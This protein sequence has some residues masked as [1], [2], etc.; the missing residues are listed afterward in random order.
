MEPLAGAYMDNG[1]DLLLHFSQFHLV[2]DRWRLLQLRRVAKAKGTDVDPT[3]N[4]TLA[5]LRELAV[6][7]HLYDTKLEAKKTA[8]SKEKKKTNPVVSDQALKQAGITAGADWQ[9]NIVNLSTLITRGFLGTALI[10]DTPWGRCH[11]SQNYAAISFLRQPGDEPKIPKQSNVPGTQRL[12]IGS[13]GTYVD[14]SGKV[15]RNHHS[16]LRFRI[17]I[18]NDNWAV[19]HTK[20]ATYTGTNAQSIAAYR[21]PL[22]LNTAQGDNKSSNDKHKDDYP[23]MYSLASWRWM[24]LGK[25]QVAT[26]MLASASA[27]A[28]ASSSSQAGTAM[29]ADQE[30]DVDAHPFPDADNTSIVATITVPYGKLYYT[31]TVPNIVLDATNTR[32]ASIYIYHANAPPNFTEGRIGVME[33]VGEPPYTGIMVFEDGVTKAYRREDGSIVSTENTQIRIRLTSTGIG[34]FEKD[35]TLSEYSLGNDFDN[36]ATNALVPLV[37]FTI[38]TILDNSDRFAGKPFYQSIFTGYDDSKPLEQ[39]RIELHQ[40]A[41]CIFAMLRRGL[42]AE[43]IGVED[44]EWSNT[45]E[46]VDEDGNVFSMRIPDSRVALTAGALKSLMQKVVRVGACSW[47]FWGDNFVPFQYESE[48]T[49]DISEHRDSLENVDARV[50]AMVVFGLLCSSF[51][52]MHL[53]EQQMQFVPGESAAFKRLAVIMV[54]DSWPV[55]LPPDWFAKGYDTSYWLS[56]FTSY[57][58]ALKNPADGYHVKESIISHAMLVI[59]SAVASP[60]HVA[61]EMAG[62]DERRIHSTKDHD[63]HFTGDA[64]CIALQQQFNFDE[65]L[66]KF[67]HGENAAPTDGDGTVG[68]TNASLVR[69]SHETAYDP[70]NSVDATGKDLPNTFDFM[71]DVSIGHMH[72][73]AAMMRV[74]RAFKGDMDMMDR[75]ASFVGT[76]VGKV[77][78]HGG[79]LTA[80]HD[81]P[82]GYA[83]LASEMFKLTNSNPVWR[84]P[85][86]ERACLRCSFVPLQDLLVYPNVPRVNTPELARTGHFDIEYQRLLRAGLNPLQTDHLGNV[87][88][89]ILASVDWSNPHKTL[90]KNVPILHMIDQHVYRGIGHVW[91]G[92]PSNLKGFRPKE[93]GFEQRFDYIFNYVTGFNPR[94]SWDTLK[95]AGKGVAFVRSAQTTILATLRYAPKLKTIIGAQDFEEVQAADTLDRGVLAGGVG[96]IGQA[97]TGFFR[98]IVYTED[99]PIGTKPRANKHSVEL[100]EFQKLGLASEKTSYEYHLSVCIGIETPD[101]IVCTIHLSR[102]GQGWGWFC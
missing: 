23:G 102:A 26:A 80:K 58:L 7:S 79:L 63:D 49:A 81:E 59:A 40:D 22:I 51:G 9:K 16:E 66:T 17:S 96:C 29:D 64:V 32:V 44:D 21:L 73:A 46:T 18:P 82:V 34:R 45:V 15:H 2:R 52:D 77:F 83:L 99:N 1:N 56:T 20:L 86:G 8:A 60:Y 25:V 97:H 76:D 57:A 31:R 37:K 24:R 95:E 43:R 42:S 90:I 36:Y 68:V 91:S 71:V 35:A 55:A 39:L 62:P 53:P 14:G 74:I 47:K 75:A 78:N 50:L 98:I 85:G 33:Q 6:L 92:W 13:H 3:Y 61:H 72:T 65:G 41:N 30:V 19:Y 54:E 94:N 101:P 67:F 88:N 10:A 11:F 5:D 27:S 38:D 70:S 89:L 84:I 12:A 100:A 48:S 87:I 93:D 4:L 28:G 69:D